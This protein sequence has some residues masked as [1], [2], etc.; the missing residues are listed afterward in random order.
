M[1]LKRN[2]TRHLFPPLLC[3]IQFA[4]SFSLSLSLFSLFNSRIVRAHYLNIDATALLLLL[5]LLLLLILLK[6]EFIY[7][8]V[9]RWNELEEKRRRSKRRRRQMVPLQECV[10]AAGDDYTPSQLETLLSFSSLSLSLSL[11]CSLY[12][13]V[14]LL[15]IITM[16]TSS[17]S[18]KPLP[19]TAPRFF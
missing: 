4:R 9:L 7:K 3:Y 5:L 11:A 14:Q 15:L 10:M 17:S 16:A 19:R 1:Q 12:T 18:S 13:H 2:P 6:Y 8:N